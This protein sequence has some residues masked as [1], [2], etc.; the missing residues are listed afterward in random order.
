MS[1]PRTP[2]AKHAGGRPKLPA[3][4]LR[5]PLSIRLLPADLDAL[6]Q[7][8]RDDSCEADD[9]SPGY[10]SSRARIIEWLIRAKFGSG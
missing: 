4:Q 8:V 2:P 1:K 7:L 5:L 3:D 9:W 10:R 6:D